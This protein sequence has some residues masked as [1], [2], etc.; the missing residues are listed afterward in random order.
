MASVLDDFAGYVA[1][2]VVVLYVSFGF[3]LSIY[4]GLIIGNIALS[5]A[6]GFKANFYGILCEANHKKAT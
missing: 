1:N 4:V 5:S 3:F 2:W 6:A